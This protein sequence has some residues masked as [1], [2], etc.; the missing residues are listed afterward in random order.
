MDKIRS[1]YQHKNYDERTFLLDEV[2]CSFC[3]NVFMID[4]DYCKTQYDEEQ[5]RDFSIYYCPYCR[6]QYLIHV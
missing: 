3:G 6:K 4:L 5:F 1:K 2:Q